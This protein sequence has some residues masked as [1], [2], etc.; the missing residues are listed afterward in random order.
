M[1][2]QAGTTDAQV[3]DRLHEVFGIGD[4][5]PETSPKTWAMYRVGEIGVMKRIRASRHVTTGELL[6][7]VEYCRAKGI[8]IR[9]PSWLYKHLRDAAAWARAET[10]AEATRDIDELIAQ[11]IEIEAAKPDSSWLDRLI[12]AAGTYREEVYREWE[13]S[14][15]SRPQR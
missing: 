14:C 11:A 5:D 10:A 6:Q 1:A 7:T 9:H 15:S 12:R 13:S 4:W 8:D 2:K 3:W